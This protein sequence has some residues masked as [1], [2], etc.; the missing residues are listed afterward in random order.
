MIERDKNKL[1]NI[2]YNM[3]LEEEVG[4]MFMVGFS[5]IRITSDIKEMIEDYCVGGVVYFKRNIES[6]NQLANLS[7]KLQKLAI[8]KKPNL[9][10]LISTDQEGGRVNRLP[11]GTHFP[12]SMIVGATQRTDYA[13]M[14][15]REIALQLKALGINMD[16]APVLD[17]NNNPLNVVI[18]TRSFGGDADLVAS[19]GAAFIKGMQKEGVI[20]CAKHFPGHGDTAIDSHLD[21]PVIK[22]DRQWM[23]EIEIYPFREAIK[24]GVDSIMT[25]HISVPAL[26]SKKGVP[27]TLSNNILTGLLRKELGFRGVIITDCM[28]M[29]PISDNSGTVEGSVMAIEAGADIVLISHSP[30]RQKAAVEKTI[31][32]V[33]KGRISAGRIEESVLRIL[34]LKEKRIGFGSTPVADYRKINREEKEK[35]AYEISKAGV[36]LVRDEDNL[37]PIKNKYERVMVINFPMEKLSIVEDKNENGGLIIDFLRKEGVTADHL[38]LS[39]GGKELSISEGTGL[40][41]VCVYDGIRNNYQVG[42][43]KELQD[44]GIPLIVI[45][46]NPYDLR[47]LP[48]IGTF[49]TIYDCSPSNLRVAGEIII[50]EY[51]AGGTLPV[52]LK[53]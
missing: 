3:T 2:L 7:N 11:E 21:L 41:M 18:G 14:V 9:P 25:A 53:I 19:M 15:G 47:L 33:E 34:K 6:L 17:I 32:S 5:G 22:H 39:D 49:L 51:K 38:T 27:A 46:G 13:E 8:N 44:T 24:S 37:I 35:I 36:T 12:G 23:E 30:D 40:I 10:L 31:K 42:K 29:K 43:I 26:E 45:S 4:Q 28:E 16:Y 52:S 20:A 50:G 1:K 48:R